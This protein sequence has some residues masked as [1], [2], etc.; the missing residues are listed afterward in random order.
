[1]PNGS[2]NCSP[3]PA[4]LLYFPNR[5]ITDCSVSSTTKKL[6]AAAIMSAPSASSQSAIPALNVKFTFLIESILPPQ[7]EI[8]RSLLHKRH[9]FFYYISD[10][11]AP[12]RA[13]AP[14]C[15]YRKRAPYNFKDI[16]DKIK[17][18]EA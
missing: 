11:P 1:M 18:Q 9:S 2:L 16:F 5:V 13:F 7:N 14:L 4:V 15:R 10:S 3:G 6:P 17:R 8:L 12:R